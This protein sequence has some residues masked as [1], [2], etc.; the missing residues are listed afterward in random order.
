MA[1]GSSYGSLFGGLLLLSTSGPFFLASGMDPF[2]VALARLSLSGLAF[3]VIYG[4][5]HPPSEGR[6]THHWGVARR[7]LGSI[8]LG[9][10]IFVVH[11]LLWMTAFEYTNFASTVLL[12]VAQPALAA[13]VGSLV[14]ERIHPAMGWSLGIAGVALVL[15]AAG[16]LN[17][18][19]RAWIGDGMCILAA[20]CTTLFVPTTRRARATLP[21]P[22]F[23]G[24]VFS[25]GALL[26]LPAAL[27][28]DVR[29]GSYDGRAWAWLLGIVFVSTVGG[30]GLN[31]LAARRLSLFRLNVV[32][33]LQP[34]IAIAIGV[35]LFEVT[36]TSW[37]LLGGALLPL[38]VAVGLW[39]TR[40]KAAPLQMTRG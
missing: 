25:I 23:L 17:L 10:L 20:L 24:L 33:L 36:T 3:L 38:A 39:G 11:L 40:E 28:V 15:V 5:Q 7:M 8:C 1:R 29:L 2:T 16:D 32:I 21:M 34:L 37:Q 6:F 27:W 31:N 18:G 9:S 19:P 30:H 35:A 12:L 22:L 4:I 14:G 26:L 13:C